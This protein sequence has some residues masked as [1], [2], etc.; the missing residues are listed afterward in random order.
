[1]SADQE[2]DDVVL[3]AVDFVGG[4]QQAPVMQDPPAAHFNEAHPHEPFAF[5]GRHV[6]QGALM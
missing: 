5:F 1:M 6:L 4:D 2:V 3:D